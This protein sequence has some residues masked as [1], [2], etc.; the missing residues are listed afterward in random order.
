MTIQSIYKIGISKFVQILN[1]NRGIN[2]VLTSENNTINI[3]QSPEIIELLKKEEENIFKLIASQQEL[4][5]QTAK[6]LES[7]FKLVELMNK[8]N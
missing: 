5:A 7:H 6:L 3:Q 2:N 4:Q 8:K 1:Y